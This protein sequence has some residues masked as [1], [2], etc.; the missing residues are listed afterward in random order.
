MR[1]WSSPPYILVFLCSFVI[2][3]QTTLWLLLRDQR[4][5]NNINNNFV[6][7]SHTLLVLYSDEDPVAAANDRL[8][9]VTMW[10][11]DPLVTSG[12][13]GFQSGKILLEKTELLGNNLQLVVK[14]GT[15]QA[16]VLL[17]VQHLG[18][19]MKDSL[20]Y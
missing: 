2:V 4:T 11:R 17:Q 7:A 20:A 1:R 9:G 12:D 8:N 3:S 13:G 10:L 6:L 18:Q 15:L 16:N 5:P 14:E 19:T